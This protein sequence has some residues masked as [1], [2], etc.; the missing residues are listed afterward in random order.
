MFWRGLNMHNLFHEEYVA[1]KALLI[2]R[3]A[4]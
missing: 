1:K 2:Q 3:L 4:D